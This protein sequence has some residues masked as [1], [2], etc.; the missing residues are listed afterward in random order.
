MKILEQCELIKVMLT[1]KKKINQK[2]TLNS[3]VT[4]FP[5]SE[6][7]TKRPKES[8]NFINSSISEGLKYVS[9]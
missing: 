8:S 2:H 5:W 6:S 4:F 3:D 7:W 1:E 9:S